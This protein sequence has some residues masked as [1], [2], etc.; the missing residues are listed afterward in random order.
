M[1]I[2]IRPI[3]EGEIPAAKKVILTVGYRIFGLNGTLENSIHYF[4]NSYGFDDMDNLQSHY[5]ATGRCFLAV[6]DDDKLIGTGA[7]R[8]IDAITAELKRIWLLETYHGQRIGYRMVTLLFN[9]ARS[10][11]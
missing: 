9:F 2:T 11:G 3:L 6:V 7:I 10:R 5:F 1:M 4:E 8:K